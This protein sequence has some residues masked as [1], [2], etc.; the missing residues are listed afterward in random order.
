MKKILSF[1]ILGIV[2]LIAALGAYIFIPIYQMKWKFHR[3]K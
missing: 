2:I 3:K 1:I